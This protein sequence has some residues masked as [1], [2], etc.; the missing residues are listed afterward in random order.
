MNTH[1]FGATLMLVAVAQLAG[2]AAHSLSTMQSEFNDI[3]RAQVECRR[4]GGSVTCAAQ[5]EP[6]FA[7]IHQRALKAAGER[8][9]DDEVK[10]A[11]LRLAAVSGWQAGLPPRAVTEV[12]KAGSAL[13]KG[14]VRARVPGDCAL[15]AAA[16]ALAEH[17]RA[18]AI[19]G[20]LDGEIKAINDPA[21]RRRRLAR[22]SANSDT[23]GLLDVVPAYADDVVRSLQAALDASRGGGA[24]DASVTQF[25]ER[26]A[27]L[28]REQVEHLAA[29][30]FDW[31]RSADVRN[32]MACE[33]A[34]DSPAAACNAE[35]LDGAARAIYST[36]CMRKELA[37]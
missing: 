10:V 16:P 28:S 32:G 6:L 8:G 21:D 22:Y 2:C 11:L 18:V 9:E 24:V 4:A 27:E 3:A 29:S 17:R 20:A 15:L 5:D 23:N 14:Q 35:R 1:R 26:Q 31:A 19:L 25:L 37:P 13:C 7:D 36:L 34:V 33:C 30:V 12:A